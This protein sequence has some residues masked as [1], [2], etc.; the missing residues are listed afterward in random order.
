MN[1]IFFLFLRRM[2]QPLLTLI[3]V[4]A[5]A[6]LG[7][8]L[9]PGQDA[10]GNPW[11]M[12]FFHAFYFVSFMST[13][14]GFGEIPYAFTEA[15]RMWATFCVY[16]TVIGWLYAIGKLLTLVQD[17]NFQQAIVERS[18]SRRVKHIREAFYLVCG[19]GETGS[20]LIQALTS[21]IGRAHV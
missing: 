19:Y 20:A 14:I 3:A 10:D 11:R 15:Q 6:I 8:V 12:D 16:A 9:I 4:Y 7:L 5:I 18:F 17:R 1:N 21:Q 2:R 13:T